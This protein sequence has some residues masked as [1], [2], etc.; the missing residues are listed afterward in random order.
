MHESNSI[1]HGLWIGANLSKLEL[2]TI[3]SFVEQGHQF[4]LWTYSDIRCPLPMGVTVKDA[5]EILPADCVFKRSI[6]DRECGLG[7]GS[8]AGFSDLFRYKLLYEHGG[9]WA[10]MDVTCLRPL[11]FSTPYLFRSHRLGAVGNLMKCPP[12]SRL[13]ELTYARASRDL[14]ENGDW[15]FGNRALSTTV[16]ELGLA[17][18]IRDDLGNAESWKEGV[19]DFI[20]RDTPIPGHFYIIHWLHECWRTLQANAGFYKGYKMAENVPDKNHARPFTTLA[21]LYEEHG[22]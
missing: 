8:C 15:H 14:N 1:V 13:M 16:R 6:V 9:Y 19:K 5:A 18:Y 20:E 4:I 21:R 2:L 12:A 22:L 10:D 7:V 17:Q 3:R 11:D